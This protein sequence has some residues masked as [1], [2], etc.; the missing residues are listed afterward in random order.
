MPKR[1]KAMT[2]KQFNDALRR[3]ELTPYSAGPVLG[4]S[5]RQ[6]HRYAAGD[7]DIPEVVAK[8]VRAYL[9]HGMPDDE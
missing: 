2:A 8:L 1:D 6:A 4:I 9:V 7:T 5:R 3:L